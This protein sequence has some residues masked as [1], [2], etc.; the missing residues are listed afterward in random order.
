MK[1][2]I[3]I[4]KTLLEID[5][6]KKKYILIMFLSSLINNIFSLLSPIAASGIVAMITVKNI[7][8]M[9]GYALLCVF[10]YIGYFF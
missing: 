9:F 4:F 6:K 5:N 2:Y 8:G 1:A 3:D 10:F 7:S